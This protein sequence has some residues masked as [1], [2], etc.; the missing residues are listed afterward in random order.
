MAFSPFA[1]LST[2]FQ[3]PGSTV[4]QLVPDAL[5]AARDPDK[6]L[7]DCPWNYAFDRHSKACRVAWRVAFRWQREYGE[8]PLFRIREDGWAA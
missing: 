8:I 5:A 4:A 7:L 3:L 6:T 1:D 2:R